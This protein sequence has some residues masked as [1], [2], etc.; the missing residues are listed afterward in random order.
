MQTG[1]KG[2][3]VTERRSSDDNTSP[4]KCDKMTFADACMHIELTDKGFLVNM[5]WLVLVIYSE[6]LKLEVAK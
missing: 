1:S 4:T 3:N 5:R 6:L 2:D